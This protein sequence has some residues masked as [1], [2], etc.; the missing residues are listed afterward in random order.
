LA[1]LILSRY[2]YTVLPA[3]DGEDA[4]RIADQHAGPI[5]LL[6]TETA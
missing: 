4:L 6:V 1:E 3:R 5:D 2:G